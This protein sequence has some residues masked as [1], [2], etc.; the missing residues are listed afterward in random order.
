MHGARRNAARHRRKGQEFCRHLYF[1]FL[2]FRFL[3]ADPFLPRI[4]T[5][6]ITKVPDFTKV[7]LPPHCSL[8]H[9]AHN[10]SHADVRAVRPVYNDVRFPFSS[11]SF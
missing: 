6:D 11:S 5:V 9:F 4:D 7:R 2:A 3:I 1:L 10:D 8:S